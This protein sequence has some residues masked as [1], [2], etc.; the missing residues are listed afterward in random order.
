M[1]AKGQVKWAIWLHADEY[2]RNYPYTSYVAQERW[3]KDAKDGTIPLFDSPEEALEWLESWLARKELLMK[4][5]S[6][7]E[8]IRK[9][10]ENG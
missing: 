4:Y 5:Y 8:F 7:K 10:I 9:E 1:V 6:A 2:R 3:V